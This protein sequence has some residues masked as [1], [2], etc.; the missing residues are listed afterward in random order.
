MN[1]IIACAGVALFLLI[2]LAIALSGGPRITR[3]TR[4]HDDFF[5]E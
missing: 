1:D 4:E 3:S 5:D 2:M